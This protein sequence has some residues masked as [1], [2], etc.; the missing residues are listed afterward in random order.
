MGDVL[1][2]RARREAVWFQR[3]RRL[4]ASSAEIIGELSQWS[5]NRNPTTNRMENNIP[6][7]FKNSSMS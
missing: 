2:D 5:N 4:V 3:P 1:E 6:R 7:D